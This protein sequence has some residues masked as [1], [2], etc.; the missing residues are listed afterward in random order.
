MFSRK[1][2]IGNCERLIE[3]LEDRRVCRNYFHRNWLTCALGHAIKQHIGTMRWAS[4]ESNDIILTK[5]SGE[6]ICVSLE[7]AARLV[8]GI[9]SMR[10]IFRADPYKAAS[11]L[12]HRGRAI[13]GLEEQIRH[14]KSWKYP[15][16]F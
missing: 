8:F 3:I 2:K 7:K 16:R 10:R 15:I 14:L 11:R 1:E 4:S 6:E 5:K 12:P 13:L 9:G